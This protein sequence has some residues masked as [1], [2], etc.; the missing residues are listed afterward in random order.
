MKNRIELAT[1]D[2]TDGILPS[3]Y[4]DLVRR[5]SPIAEGEYRL[6]WAILED[7][8]RT[9]L[10]N[11]SCSNAAERRKFEDVRD[12]FEPAQAEARALFDFQNVCDLLGIDSRRLLKGLKALDA[13]KLS[14][15][16]YRILPIAGAQKLAA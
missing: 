16:P 2:L 12:W 5:L 3:Q 13:R 15:K 9:Y 4:N 8:I 1:E 14:S 6:L 10:A 7:A 11:R